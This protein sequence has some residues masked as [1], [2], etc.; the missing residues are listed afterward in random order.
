MRK[1]L[2]L[3]FLI[4]N[5]VFADVQSDA[6]LEFCNGALKTIRS[7]AESGI[8]LKNEFIKKCPADNLSAECFSRSNQIISRIEDKANEIKL[9]MLATKKNYRTVALTEYWVIMWR[10]GALD[11]FNIFKEN[12]SPQTIALNIYQQCKQDLEEFDL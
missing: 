9:R 6:Q 1:L 5:L 10:K 7:A 3:L 4:P 2:L 12:K 8:K 11:G